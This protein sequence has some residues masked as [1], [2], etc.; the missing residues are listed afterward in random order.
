M[1]T[2]NV[3][4]KN[5][6][7]KQGMAYYFLQ[8][9]VI[10][11]YLFDAIMEAFGRQSG[12]ISQP[13]LKKIHGYTSTAKVLLA[14]DNPVNQM[15][16]VEILTLAG[17]TVHKAVNGKEAIEKI[18]KENFDVVLMDVQ[19]PE[20]DG[21]EA[22]VRIRR[23]LGEKNLPIIA[24][25]AHAMRGDREK[26]IA[27]GMN[28]YISKPIDRLKLYKVLSKH[29][30]NGRLNYDP[31][32][33]PFEPDKRDRADSIHIP[34]IDVD[35]G[36]DLM[37]C[38]FERYIVILS[39]FFIDLYPVLNKLKECIQQDIPAEAKA[40]T[41]S[42][43]GSA[44]NLCITELYSASQCL[45]KAIEKRDTDEIN[46][47]LLQ[48]EQ[49]FLEAKEALESFKAGHSVKESGILPREDQDN[50]PE[51]LK[52]MLQDLDKS[53]EEY[54]P[55][56]SKIKFDRFKKYLEDFQDMELSTLSMKLE[57]EISIYQ[58]EKARQVIKT[59]IQKP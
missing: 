2:L 53:L 7:V 48:V 37:G 25:T 51:K 55:A 56:L 9:P 44:G 13:D 19:M 16:A 6:A 43:K 22:T 42:L 14:E 5:S 29:I 28:D 30:P 1:D 47:R 57:N 34:G 58:F 21:L 18:K 24:M 11:S 52:T 26:C 41:H 45:E 12:F 40:A 8:K 32:K 33:T 49:Y 39:Q 4:E 38:S 54:D 31:I 35:K 27:A 50:D 36:M 46:T 23:D 3:L 20:M 15:V 17:M 59:F 10:P